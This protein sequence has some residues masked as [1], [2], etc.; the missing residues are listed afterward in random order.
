MDIDSQVFSHQIEVVN[1]L[2]ANFDKVYGNCSDASYKLNAI[3]AE[4]SM[5]ELLEFVTH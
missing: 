5:S 2:A 3:T 1:L 4:G